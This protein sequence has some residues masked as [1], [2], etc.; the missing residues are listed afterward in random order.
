MFADSAK[1]TMM[2]QRDKWV[3]C[4]LWY[5]CVHVPD[6]GERNPLGVHPHVRHNII[7]SAHDCNCL[8]Y[9]LGHSSGEPERADIV[10]LSRST[11]SEIAD[12]N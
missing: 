3:I 4:L 11:C 12:S 1:R 10:V 8:I 6:S 9:Q 2:P 5:R 7:L